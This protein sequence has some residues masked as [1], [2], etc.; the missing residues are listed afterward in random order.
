MH[1][2]PA[3]EISPEVFHFRTANEEVDNGVLLEAGLTR[4]RV[5]D[6]DYVEVVSAQY[7][8]I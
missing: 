2:T 1:F 4:W 3:E 5:V 8:S 7:E 6:V